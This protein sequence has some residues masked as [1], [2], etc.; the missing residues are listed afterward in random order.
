MSADPTHTCSHK[1]ISFSQDDAYHDPFP[2]PRDA[3]VCTDHQYLAGPHQNEGGTTAC[4]AILLN[5]TVSSILGPCRFKQL[6]L[7]RI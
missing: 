2:P 7:S 3:F 1:L 6:T 5:G 4:V